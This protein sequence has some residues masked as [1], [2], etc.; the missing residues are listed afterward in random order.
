[1]TIA[2]TKIVDNTSK[3]IVQ[4]KGIKDETDQIVVDA[5]KLASGNNETLVSLI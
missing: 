1:M 5:E 3:Y 2:N 4:S